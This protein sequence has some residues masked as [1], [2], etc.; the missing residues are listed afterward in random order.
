MLIYKKMCVAMAVLLV[1]S[2]SIVTWILLY[3]NLP[4]NSPIRAK[5]VFYIDDTRHISLASINFLSKYNTV[6]N[7]QTIGEAISFN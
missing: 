5:Q 2:G 7:V 6:R 3:G 1:I 4:H